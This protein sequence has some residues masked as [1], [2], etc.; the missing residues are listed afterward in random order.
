MKEV[1][2]WLKL[3]AVA[4]LVALLAALVRPPVAGLVLRVVAVGLAAIVAVLAVRLVV[5]KLD[6]ADGIGRKPDPRAPGDLPR[7]LASLT[8]ELRGT[9][10]RDSLPHRTL[11]V[12]RSSIQHR[13]WQHRR[14]S[15]TSPNDDP[16][17][18][19][20]LS[21]NAYAVLRHTPPNPPPL[22]P[23][24]E[25]PALIEEVERL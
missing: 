14:L 6:P 12:L 18:R 23:A 9:Q 17:I 20:A 21:A 2:G 15:A 8:E 3:A 19:A 7:E 10:R 25:L 13:L 11:Y 4:A 24:T 16:A 5:G 22:I 1:P